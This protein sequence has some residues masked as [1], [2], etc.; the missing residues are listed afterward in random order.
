MNRSFDPTFQKCIRES[1]SESCHC[2][3]LVT[4][5]I[6]LSGTL[7]VDLLHLRILAKRRNVSGCIMTKSV[8]ASTRFAQ[9]K[10]VSFDSCLIGSCGLCRFSRLALPERHSL[11]SRYLYFSSRR[12]SRKHL[13]Y[14]VI[15][16]HCQAANDSRLFSKTAHYS[17]LPIKDTLLVRTSAPVSRT[18]SATFFDVAY[19]L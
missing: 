8:S 18:S 2:C 4:L 5:E 15:L 9:K 1:G 10:K 14:P 12:R 17:A 7:E 16:L 11:P 3:K 19:D 6:N 13:S